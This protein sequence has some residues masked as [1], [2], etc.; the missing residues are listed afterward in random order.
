MTDRLKKEREELCVIRDAHKK[1]IDELES[2]VSSLQQRSKNPPGLPLSNGC[3]S[4]DT[5]NYYTGL[6]NYG[7]FSLVINLV[8]FGILF[9]PSLVLTHEQEILLVLMKLS[10]CLDHRDLAHCFG[11]TVF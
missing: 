5:V 3:H 2:K 11:I 9:R 7:T 8:S 4:A 1:E 6:P 10:L